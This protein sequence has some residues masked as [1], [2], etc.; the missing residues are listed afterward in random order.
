MKLIKIGDANYYRKAIGSTEAEV[1]CYAGNSQGRLDQPNHWLCAECFDNHEDS[2]K[3]LKFLDGSE[4]SPTE[5]WVC[6]EI[7]MITIDKGLR[8]S[9]TCLL[10]S[11]PPP[12]AKPKIGFGST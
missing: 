1:L 12:V 6:G 9:N 4:F 8:P 11:E 2:P 3:R 7:H 5:T 10:D